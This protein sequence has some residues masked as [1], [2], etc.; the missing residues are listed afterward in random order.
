MTWWLIL[1]A[2][3]VFPLAIV[4]A[5]LMRYRAQRRKPPKVRTAL[6]TRPGWHDAIARQQAGSSADRQP[7]SSHLEDTPSDLP[8]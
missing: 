5:N 8:Q 4:G 7:P 2:A 3:L 1:I 6:M